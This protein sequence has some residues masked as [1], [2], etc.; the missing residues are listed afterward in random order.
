[1]SLKLFKFLLFFHN[2]SGFFCHRYS[3]KTFVVSKMLLFVNILK[4]VFCLFVSFYVEDNRELKSNFLSEDLFDLDNFS[5]FS[6]L[7]VAISI[8]FVQVTSLI[9][10]LIQMIKR[11]KIK[12][13]L[14]AAIK[15]P[16]NDRI[17]T[18]FLKKSTADIFIWASLFFTLTL[19]KFLFTSKIS[20]LSFLVYYILLLP[21]FIVQSLIV[22]IKIFQN[23]AITLLQSLQDDLKIRK[24]SKSSKH[25]LKAQARHQE[26]Y[27]LVSHFNDTFG[28]QMTTVVCC[29]TFMIVF[30]V[31]SFH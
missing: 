22:S 20:L 31:S 16:V 6:K 2:L 4:I 19:L 14:N 7:S 5:Q 11:K 26:I 25:N 12:K 30:R 8:S 17:V 9:L 1:M 29:I 23:F 3:N 13:F 18:N 15:I 10:F 27:D 28:T 21:S 24:L